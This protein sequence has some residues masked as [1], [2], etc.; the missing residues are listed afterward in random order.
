VDLKSTIASSEQVGKHAE[1]NIY[2][3]Y[4]FERVKAK[5]GDREPAIASS[6]SLTRALRCSKSPKRTS[7]AKFH[8]CAKHGGAIPRSPTLAWSGCCHGPG[9]SK[10]LE[11]TEEMVKAC[12]AS[13]GRRF[14][15][16]RRP[17]YDPGCRSESWPG[18]AY[19]Y[20]FAGIFDLG[21]WLE[22][23]IAES[24]GKSA[25]AL[26]QL[27]ASAQ[28]SQLLMA[29]IGSSLIC[30]WRRSQTRRKM[31]RLPRSKRLGTPSCAS[32]S[33]ILQSRAGIL[34]LGNRHGRR[35]LILG[36]NAFNQPD[37]E[38]SKMETKK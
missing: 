27:I 38:A 3:Q 13:S 29:T 37:V 16:R 25:R 10:F 35:R 8:G 9:R 21:A 15:S 32:L 7:S 20:H 14:E 34:P 24:T 30:G 5:V 12:G 19:D 2:K 18:Q 11:N 31:P 17:R 33:R 6:L 22:Q 26:F 36:I 28:P 1:P 23:L 4:F